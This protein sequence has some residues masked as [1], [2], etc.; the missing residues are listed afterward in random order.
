MDVRLWF[1]LALYNKTPLNLGNDTSLCA[2]ASLLLDAG[3]SICIYHNSYLWST[4]DTTQ[5]ITVST[6]EPTVLQLQLLAILYQMK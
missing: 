5:T 4:G 2:S 3:T 6:Q 1:C